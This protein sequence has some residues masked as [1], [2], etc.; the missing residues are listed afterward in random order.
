MFTRSTPGCGTLDGPS[1]AW[2]ASLWPKLRRSKG[3]LGLKLPI[4]ALTRDHD[5]LVY[6]WYFQVYTRNILPVNKTYLLGTI[7]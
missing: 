7:E 3:S 1:L 4:T 5:C 2:A 6:I